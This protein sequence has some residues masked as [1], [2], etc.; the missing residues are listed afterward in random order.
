MAAIGQRFTSKDIENDEVV[1]VQNEYNV[2]K[3]NGS[4]GTRINIWH[5][6]A[7]KKDKLKDRVKEILEKEVKGVWDDAT[8]TFHRKTA[9]MRK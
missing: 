7:S 4:G 6:R 1:A 9:D 5:K 2:A 8:K 3:A